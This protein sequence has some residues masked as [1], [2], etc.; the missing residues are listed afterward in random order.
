MVKYCRGVVIKMIKKCVRG[1]LILGMVA[2]ICGIA[3]AAVGIIAETQTISVGEPQVCTAPCECISMNEAAQRWG[4]EGYETCSK[5][6]CGQSGNAMTQYYCI[7]QIG[8]T[9]SSAVTTCQAPYE[10]LT[11]SGAMAKWGLNGYTQSGKAVCARDATSG[12]DIPLYCFRQFGSGLLVGGPTSALP[13][14]TQQ[15]VNAPAQI[16]VPAQPMVSAAAAPATPTPSYS[17][18][19][20]GPLQTRSP[21]SIVTI[22][23]AIGIAL[24]C[25]AGLRRK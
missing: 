8:G 13:A 14:S 22:L 25:A 1:L 18:P 12:G 20:P 9:G 15:T 10:C 3:G 6:I 5:S 2:V 19:T 11:E 24:V 21:V 17:W 23:S 4:A 7:H 16:P